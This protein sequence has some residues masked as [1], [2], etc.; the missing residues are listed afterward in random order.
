MKQFTF[1]KGHFGCSCPV[2]EH[3]HESINGDLWTD[4]WSILEAEPQDLWIG[5]KGGEDNREKRGI[6]DD[7]LLA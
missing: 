4:S 7:K 1:L 2:R 6:K 5:L 3:V